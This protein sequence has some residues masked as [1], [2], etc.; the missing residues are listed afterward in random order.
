MRTWCISGETQP[1]GVRKRNLLEQNKPQCQQTKLVQTESLLH[2]MCELCYVLL[3]RKPGK[4]LRGWKP[5]W[6]WKRLWG[7]RPE[8]RGRGEKKSVVETSLGLQRDGI[9]QCPAII[10]LQAARKVLVFAIRKIFLWA[11]SQAQVESSQMWPL[12]PSRHPSPP[13]SFKSLLSQMRQLSWIWRNLMSS[14]LKS[15]WRVNH[16]GYFNWCLSYST[17]LTQL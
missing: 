16:P 10:S 4:P 6:V 11:D 2:H 17:M 3:V 13:S 1:H 9:H 7:K 5:K 8:K 12:L 14:C 15:Q